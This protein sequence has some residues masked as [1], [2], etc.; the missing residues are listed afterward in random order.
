NGV[1]LNTPIDMAAVNGVRLFVFGGLTLNNITQ[2]I[3][4][5]TGIGCTLTF[6]DSGTLGGTGTVQLN[7]GFLINEGSGLTLTIGPNIVVEARAAD[8]G[9][10]QAK[11]INQGTIRAVGAGQTLNV[12]F[13]SVN[14]GGASTGFGANSGTVEALNGSTINLTGGSGWTNSGT[15]NAS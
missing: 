1:T 8:I 13:G 3:G 14:S 4:N 9:Y 6:G 10:D 2:P 15:I 12:K 7:S 5:T 11:L